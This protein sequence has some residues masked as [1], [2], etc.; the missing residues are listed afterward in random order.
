MRSISRDPRFSSDSSTA[1]L[2]QS[3]GVN[4]Y[5]LNHI[6][7]I[8]ISGQTTA[9]KLRAALAA[10]DHEI[11]RFDS[12]GYVSAEEL[13]EVKAQRAVNSAFGRER[14]SGY[15][16]TIGFWWSVANLEYYFGYVDNMAAQTAAGPRGVCPPLH[17]RQAPRDRRAD[18]ARRPGRGRT[19]RSRAQRRRF[20]DSDLAPDRPSYRRSSAPRRGLCRHRR[21]QSR[22][23]RGSSSTAFP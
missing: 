20:S 14:A 15:A 18:R 4:Y 22:T 17:R 11:A 19:D 13:A 16:H 9:D 6:G 23:R 21:A 3:I 2:F 1:G 10:L 8:T 5:T 12:V 7:P